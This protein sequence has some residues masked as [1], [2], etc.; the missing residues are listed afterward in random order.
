MKIDK[1][2]PTRSKIFLFLFPLSISYRIARNDL[3]SPYLFLWPFEYL[4]NTA[5]STKLRVVGKSVEKG[6]MVLK[7]YKKM[8]LGRVSV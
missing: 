7:V 5:Y 2:V 4:Q 6:G 8:C 1:S 3:V